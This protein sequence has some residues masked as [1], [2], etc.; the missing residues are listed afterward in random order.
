[1]PVTGVKM[2]LQLPPVGS[3][4]HPSGLVTAVAVGSN[5][6]GSVARM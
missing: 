5:E 2:V 6:A 1:M 3:D 4:V